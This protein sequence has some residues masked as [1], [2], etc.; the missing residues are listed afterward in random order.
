MQHGAEAGRNVI[1][2]VCDPLVFTVE[3]K[4]TLGDDEKFGSKQADN[5]FMNAWPS[6]SFS[7]RF[8]DLKI[9]SRF[10]VLSGARS[11]AAECGADKKVQQVND[12]QQTECGLRSKII[13]TCGWTVCLSEVTSEAVIGSLLSGRKNNYSAGK[14]WWPWG[15]L[16]SFWFA[17]GWL[18]WLRQ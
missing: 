13:C 7:L 9:K 11:G 5:D 10:V 15:F 17:G 1:L 4:G 2:Q 12:W 18:L 6:Y 8:S 14:S 16:F 3:A